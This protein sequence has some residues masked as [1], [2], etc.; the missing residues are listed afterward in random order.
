MKQVLD[1]L[2]EAIRKSGNLYDIGVITEAFE[3][4]DSAHADQKRKSGEPYI[5]HPVAV[6]TILVETVEM[7]TETITAALLHDVVEDTEIKLEEI[8]KKFGKDVAHLV[9]GVTK[10]KKL[11]FSSKE[12]QQSEKVSQILYAVAK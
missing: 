4:A 8:Q 2:L 7:D 5:I 11:P 3:L 1:G 9:D 10:L 6:A 12:Q